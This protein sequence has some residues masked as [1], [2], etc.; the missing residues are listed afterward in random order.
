M[1]TENGERKVLVFRFPFSV[2]RSFVFPIHAVL[3][4]LHAFAQATHEFRDFPTAED[5][6]YNQSNEKDFLIADK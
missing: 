4:A 1:K 6:Q 2:F 5:Q 3:E